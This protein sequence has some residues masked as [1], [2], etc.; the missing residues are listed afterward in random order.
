ME[1]AATSEDFYREDGILNRLSVPR[2][3]Q[4]IG[5]LV[6]LLLC[7]PMHRRYLVNDIGAVFFPPIHL[8]QFRIYRSKDRV[9]GFVTWAFVSEEVERQYLSGS[10][11]MKPQDWNC[12]ERI[13][14]IDFMAP[15]GHAK[16]IIHDLRQNIFP[17]RTG[18]AVR[19]NPDGKVKGIMK[20]RGANSTKTKSTMN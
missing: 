16:S 19:I 12:G 3:N 7:S 15:F 11:N 6:S 10:Y 2:R 18:S 1:R 8:N 17:D 20:L 14:I 13:W 9:I 5:E 4:L